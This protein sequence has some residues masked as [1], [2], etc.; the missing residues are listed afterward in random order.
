MEPLSQVCVWGGG[1]G[2]L[3]ARLHWTEYFGWHHSCAA[4]RPS[5]CRLQP[6]GKEANPI[7]VSIAPTFYSSLGALAFAHSCLLLSVFMQGRETASGG[8]SV[9]VIWLSVHVDGLMGLDP[10]IHQTTDYVN[11]Q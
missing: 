3:K 10:L 1:G 9:I 2:P 6:S 8:A 11:N 5:A 4:S 7:P